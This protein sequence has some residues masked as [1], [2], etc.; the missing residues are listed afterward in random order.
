M[1]NAVLRSAITQSQ[2]SLP[3]VFHAGLINMS[4]ISACDGSPDGLIVRRDSRRCP[5]ND[6]LRRPAADMNTEDR[7]D[8][9]PHSSPAAAVHAAQF[10]GQRG[11]PRPETGSELIRNTASDRVA[12][13]GAFPFTEKEMRDPHH[14][15]RRFSMLMDLIFPYIPEFSAAAG[16]DGRTNFPCLCRRHQLL[17]TAPPFFP[18]LRHRL[19]PPLFL[20]RRVGRRRL[21]RV[22]GIFAQFR[23]K[24]FDP[25]SLPRHFTDKKRQLLQNRR[26]RSG[27]V[28]FAYLNIFGTERGSGQSLLLWKKLLPAIYPVTMPSTS[29]FQRYPVS[30]YEMSPL[31]ERPD[32]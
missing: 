27:K 31:L 1:K 21:I 15:F 14:D 6:F 24:L 4:G 23:L 25:L 8:E 22:R 17:T 20:I 26:R 30:A 5:V 9:L 3:P 10:G 29:V 11:E 13:S 32:C 28:V 19:A 16:A 12:A 18:R 7:T 2:C